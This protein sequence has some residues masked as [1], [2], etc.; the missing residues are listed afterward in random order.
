MED[1]RLCHNKLI[2]GLKRLKEIEESVE[3]ESIS[4]DKYVKELARVSQE[5]PKA[6]AKMSEQSIC[7]ASPWLPRSTMGA[8]RA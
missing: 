1:S 6:I 8:V 2:E 4:V 7:G 3:G 5:V